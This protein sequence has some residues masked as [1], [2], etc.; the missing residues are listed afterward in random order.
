MNYLEILTKSQ[1][2]VLSAV[3][4]NL[5]AAW[6]VTLLGTKDVLTLLSNAVFAIVCIVVALNA[7]SLIDQTHD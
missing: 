1:L 4:T 3:A 7:E 2:R 5:A 6:L